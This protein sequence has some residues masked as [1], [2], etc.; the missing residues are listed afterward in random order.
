MRLEVNDAAAWLCKA[1][2]SEYRHSC[3]AYWRE[4]F[5]DLYADE[6]EKVAKK[7]FKKK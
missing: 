2:T 6:V 4:K 7:M 1:L 5:G 3:L